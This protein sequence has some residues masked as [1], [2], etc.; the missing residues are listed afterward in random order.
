MI[1]RRIIAAAVLLWAS[2]CLAQ[3]GSVKTPSQLNTEINSTYPD[4]NS[5]AITPF[6][7]RQVS[8]D[9]VASV[10]FL[11]FPNTFLQLQTF[12][13]GLTVAGTFTAP[14]L[15]TNAD[16]A[17]PS[18]SVNGVTCTLGSTC[19]ITATATS[20]LTFGAHLTA[21]GAS[22]NGSTPVTIT[23]DATNA[24]TASTIVARDGS[25]NFAAGTIA[26]SL[27]G[28]ASL[29]LAISALGVGVQTALGVNTGSAGAFVLFNGAG[30]TP[31]SLGLAS[32]TGLP[33]STG[34]T[35]T[36]PIANNCPGSTGA[37]SS[38]FLRGDCTWSTPAGGGNVSTGAT[39]TTN[40]IV[41]GAGTTN[42]GVSPATADSSGNLAAVNAITGNVIATKTQQQT[43]S[44]AN[45]IVTP[46]QQQQ[47]DSAAKAWCIFNG[48][49]TG[50]N[51]C[52]AAYNVTS[53][54]RVSAGNYVV[55]FTTAFAS[56]NYVCGAMS[57]A[58][59]V[60]LFAIGSTTP[61][62][63][64]WSFILSNLS[65]TAADSALVSLHC[66]GRQ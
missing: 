50:T 64:A 17:N 15:V 29:D 33:L 35:G 54:Q 22:Y 26:A 9:Q 7:L 21:G 13:L 28:H 52:T 41:T 60:V 45:L 57:Q 27:T 65:G 23:S 14:G 30:G 25:G 58:N 49:I 51:A 47:H 8:L 53:V 20:T 43:G 34:I 44:A 40:E 42:V 11:N 38:T 59:G 4:N 1:S 16:L 31:S 10:P 6:V 5:N 24:N 39:L 3:T 48:T 12:S 37:S 56:A 55:N 61:T 19:T 62:G 18:T 63:S 2:P 32:A 46:S 36:L 66:F